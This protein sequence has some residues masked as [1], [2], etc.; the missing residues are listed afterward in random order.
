MGKKMDFLESI[1]KNGFISEDDEPKIRAYAIEN[2]ISIYYA[3]VKMGLLKEKVVV[4]LMNQY[5]KR[6]VV[7]KLD[8]SVISKDLAFKFGF[9]TLKEYKFVPYK[10]DNGVLT[11]LLVEPYRT[12]EIKDVISKTDLSVES[13]NFYI[14]YEEAYENWIDE[15]KIHFE[16][17]R[18][19]QIQDDVSIVE[20]FE[21][22]PDTY[23]LENV[24]ESQIASIVK[25]IFTKAYLAGASDIHIEPQKDEIRVRFRI[26]GVLQLSSTHP[27]S[28]GKLI[29][30]RIKVL[31]KMNMND[32]KRPQGGN[33]SLSLSGK[34]FGLRISTLPT[35]LGEKITIRL[36]D[37]AENNF[38]IKSLCLNDESYEKLTNAI[39]QPN[40][41]I[42]IVGATGSGKSTTLF[43]I[44]NKLNTMDKNIITI[45]DP[46]E[47][48]IYGTNQT[49]VNSA[50][51][52]TFAS[53]FREV[54]RQDPDIIMV[55]EIRDGETA[56]IANQAAMSG[57]LVFSTLHANNS[58]AAVARMQTM[59]VKPEDL[60]NSLTAV[61]SQTL[62]RKLCPYCKEEY[63]MDIT[64]PFRGVVDAYEERIAQLGKD[65][66]DTEINKITSR[67]EKLKLLGKQLMEVPDRDELINKVTSEYG[68]GNTKFYRAHKGGC[69]ECNGIGYTGRIAL[70]ELLEITPELRTAIQN[71]A[72]VQDIRDIALRQGM[73]SLEDEGIHKAVQGITSME[74]LHSRIHF[75]H[76]DI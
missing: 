32:T 22:T 14:L 25:N 47:Y 51:G 65:K 2:G 67:N 19:D 62:V 31:G 12:H 64:N 24:E 36:L 63:E 54:L 13:I 6:E 33:L 45:E 3:I 28:L 40:G 20:G 69:K 21:D 29:V 35:Y 59:G 15:I 71:N 58:C 38:D 17:N 10:L 30:N 9:D 16:M 34:T 66:A 11:V 75:N 60:S 68:I 52:L 26:D 43:A 61:L 55:G 23:S 70:V 5:F 56:E 8:N 46:V 42:L 27:L 50:Q 57:H 49:H 37:V 72:T 44:L 76:V 73:V 41:I 48:K 39:G 74:E 18:V 7:H 4:A 53:T 1:I